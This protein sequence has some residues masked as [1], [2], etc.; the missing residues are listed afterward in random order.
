MVDV[1]PAEAAELWVAGAKAKKA[2]YEKGVKTTAKGAVSGAIAKEDKFKASMQN[3]IDND[4]HLKGLERSSD[5]E[6][7]SAT[8]AALNKWPSGIEG[9]KEK[10][11]KVLADILPAT[12]AVRDEVL[13]MPDS[14]L[15]ERI[16]RSAEYQRKRA[17]RPRGT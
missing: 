16:E 13:T 14:T 4:L 3:V 7:R 6:W 8:I 17:A 9:S 5:P 10:M 1:T 11:Q 12:Y 15:D 2:R